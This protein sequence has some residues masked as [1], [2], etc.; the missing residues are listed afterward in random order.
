MITLPRKCRL[1]HRACT[2]RKRAHTNYTEQMCPVREMC[3]CWKALHTPAGS[4]SPLVTSNG[5]SLCR[6]DF[7]VTHTRPHWQPVSA[8]S[9]EAQPLCRGLRQRP[10]LTSHKGTESA[11]GVSTDFSAATF[12][13]ASPLFICSAMTH[14]HTHRIKGRLISV[15]RCSAGRPFARTLAI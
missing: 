3:R 15:I 6:H 4:Q 12:A 10:N 11:L 9:L 14:A 2:R 7:A 8:A 13:G 1:N 5:K